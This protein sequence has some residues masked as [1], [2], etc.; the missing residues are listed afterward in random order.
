MKWC[1]QWSQ[2]DLHLQKLACFKGLFMKAKKKGLRTKITFSSVFLLFFLYLFFMI[3]QK[4]KKKSESK[5]LLKKNKK[6][7]SQ[8]LLENSISKLKWKEKKMPETTT[9][10]H[11]LEN[12]LAVD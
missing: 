2:S 9:V 8:L 3:C 10:L 1:A 12:Q 5:V 7:K 4:P 11:S 6:K